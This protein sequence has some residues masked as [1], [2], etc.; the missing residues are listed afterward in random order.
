MALTTLIGTAQLAAGRAAERGLHDSVE[1]PNLYLVSLSRAALRES[2]GDDPDGGVEQVR[3]GVEATVAR[4]AEAHDWRVGG[5]GTIVVS[6]AVRSI[7]EVCDVE[8]VHARQLYRLTVS[9]DRGTRAL[10]IVLPVVAVGRAHEPHPRGFV[11]VY[12]S[13]RHISRDHLQFR[14]RDGLLAG[15]VLGRNPTT[16]NNHPFTPEAPVA[17]A[18][19]DTIRCGSCSFVV[20]RFFGEGATRS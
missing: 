19:G 8:G 11:P 13:G 2:Y 20:D 12:D 10:P 15:L 9:D 14:W 17:L 16:L 4:V 6:M 5:G 1:V 7:R 18:E 3:R